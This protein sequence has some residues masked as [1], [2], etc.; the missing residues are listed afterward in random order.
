[1]SIE[2]IPEL[3]LSSIE[4][5]RLTSL[6]LYGVDNVAKVPEFQRRQKKTNL[7][8]YGVVNPMQNFIVFQRHQNAIYKIK[9]FKTELGTIIEYQGYEDVLL[10]FLID[11]VKLKESIIITNRSYIPKIFYDNPITG[12]TSRYYPDIWLKDTNIIFEVKSK[13]TLYCDVERTLI[14]QE[15][16][17]MLGYKCIIVVCSKNDILEFIL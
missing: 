2:I 10:K 17:N 11:Y 5:R 6:S 15:A 16:C 1:M 9:K 8:K 12:G 13:Y 14:K 4:K 7:E 3:K